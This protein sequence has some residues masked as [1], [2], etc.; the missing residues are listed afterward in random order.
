MGDTNP[1]ELGEA[2]KVFRVRYGGADLDMFKLDEIIHEL[3]EKKKR[4]KRKKK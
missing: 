1:Q 4:P 3:R 2:I